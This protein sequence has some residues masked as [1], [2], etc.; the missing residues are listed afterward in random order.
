MKLAV[1]VGH[2]SARQGAVRQD[3]GESEFDGKRGLGR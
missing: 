2:N 1:V 3:T